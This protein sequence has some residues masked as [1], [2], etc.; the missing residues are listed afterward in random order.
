MLSRLPDL[1][2]LDRR[3]AG[4]FEREKLDTLRAGAAEAAL[5]RA[6]LDLADR[7]S[8]LI[9]KA[10]RADEDQNFTLF[11]GEPG[12]SLAKIIEVEMALLIAR[13]DETSGVSPSLS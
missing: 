13:H 1:F 7:G 4:P 11:R 10:V 12:E 6:D 5:D 8:L 9:R 3:L 2:A